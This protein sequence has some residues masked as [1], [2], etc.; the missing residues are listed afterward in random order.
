MV[1]LSDLPWMARSEY[2]YKEYTL[3]IVSSNSRKFLIETCNAPDYIVD[4]ADI[5]CKS[6]I[7]IPLDTY[8]AK[9]FD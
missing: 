4:A 3:Y 2:R 5:W 9:L 1:N 7:D 6:N 8:L